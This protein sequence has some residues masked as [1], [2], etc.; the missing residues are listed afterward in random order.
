MSFDESSSA[1]DESPQDPEHG[2]FSNPLYQ[3][4]VNSFDGWCVLV[5]AKIA[6]LTAAGWVSARKIS[7]EE[8]LIR[9]DLDELR[10]MA[11]GVLRC[12]HPHGKD[13]EVFRAA[14]LRAAMALLKNP[15]THPS[16]ADTDG[17]KAE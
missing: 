3:K 1:Q 2:K 15:N 7:R 5:Q 9:A 11:L 16:E 14:C 13:V 6:L 4:F 17:T 12:P 10:R 8:R